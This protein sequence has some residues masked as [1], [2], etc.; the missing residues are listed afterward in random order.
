MGTWLTED[1]VRL[2]DFLAIVGASTDLADYPHADRL[3]REVL[4]YRSEVLRD[5]A[6]S[7]AGRRGVQAELVRALMDGP[8]LVVFTDAFPD[9]SAVD[10]ATAAFHALIDAQRASGTTGGDHFAKPGANDRVWN[11]LE[12]LALSDPDVF[13]DYYANDIIALVCDAW[14][15]PS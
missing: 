7:P 13:V 9:T 4:I 8:G 1:D 11:A 14:L 2:E 15:G 5:A 6:G 12:K 10:R 3:E